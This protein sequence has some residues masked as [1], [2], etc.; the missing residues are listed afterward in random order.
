MEKLRS[1]LPSSAHKSR[2]CFSNGCGF[3][4]M[5]DELVL[6]ALIL[7]GFHCLLRTGELLSIRPCDFLVE[8]T[9]G[10]VTLPSSKSGA[11]NNTKESVSITDPTT[12]EVVRAM[13]HLQ[14]QLGSRQV[15]CWTKA[16][17][18]SVTNF[19]GS[20]NSLTFLRWASGPILLG[21]EGQPTKCRTMG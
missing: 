16:G 7:L 8:A 14:T 20:W 10:L 17:L 5:E 18:L 15:S 4:L 6:A 1:S 19:A 13:V 9:R 11:R 21:E 2:H 3:C 12:L